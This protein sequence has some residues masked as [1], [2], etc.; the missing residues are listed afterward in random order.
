[1]S[2]NPDSVGLRSASFELDYDWKSLVLYALGIGAKA[3]ELD[4]LYEARGP[5]VYPTY[6]VVPTYPVLMDLLE[7]SGASLSGVVHNAQAITV[8]RPLPSSGRLVTS[9]TVTGIYDLKR[10]AQM[11]FSTQST[12]GGELVFETEWSLLLLGAGGFGGPRPPRSVMSRVPAGVQP[13]FVFEE[14]V[15]PEQAMLYRLSGDAN[16]LHIDPEVARRVGFEQGPILHGLA[17]FG[18]CARALTLERLGGDAARLATLR[19]QFR[20]P[21]WPGEALR[22]V[23]YEL[24]GQVRIDAFAGGREEP[25]ALCAAQLA[26][27]RE[28]GARNASG[29][30]PSL[31]EPGPG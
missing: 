1:M 13:S 12:L 26:D 8:H 25:V 20:K 16:P 30:L 17:T 22:I 11:V 15:S 27:A 7:R 9:G 29:R 18:Y 14:V 6:A 24:E 4:Y 23:G 5:K 28:G 2:L 10:M 3:S 31:D 19:A 21:V